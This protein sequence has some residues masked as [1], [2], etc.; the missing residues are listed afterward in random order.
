MIQLCIVI[1]KFTL[2]AKGVLHYDAKIQ[3]K[4]KAKVSWGCS[5]NIREN[6]IWLKIR[7]REKD[8]FID[9][10]VKPLTGVN[11]DKHICT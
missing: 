5:I 7:T 6:R 9:K 2:N 10:R 11:N 1:K 3:C 4:Q 8:I